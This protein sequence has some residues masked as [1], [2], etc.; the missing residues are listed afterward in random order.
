[1]ILF[2]AYLVKKGLITPAQ[3][4]TGLDIQKQ[5]W[6]P[7]GRIAFNEDKLSVEQIFEILNKQIEIKKTFGE[8]AIELGYLT[9][10]AVSHLLAIQQ[11]NIRPIGEIF[12]ELG[13]IKQ[14]IMERELSAFMKNPDL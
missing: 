6:L 2:G 8:I 7:I 3:A 11:K 1:M 10:E 14:D 12:V 4:M 13:Y 5:T 9:S